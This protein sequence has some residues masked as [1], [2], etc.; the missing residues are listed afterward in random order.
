MCEALLSSISPTSSNDEVK[1]T[2]PSSE[3]EKISS[4][5]SSPTKKSSFSTKKIVVGAVAGAIGLTLATP[6]VITAL[7]FTATGIVGGSI[8]SG[9]MASYGGAVGVGSACA[10]LQSIGAVGLSTTG[11]VG[12]STTGSILGTAV[13]TFIS[14]KNTK[15]IILLVNEDDK[16]YKDPIGAICVFLELTLRPIP[17]WREAVRAM[18]WSL[19]GVNAILK[20]IDLPELE[21]FPL[22][23]KSSGTAVLQFIAKTARSSQEKWKK[24]IPKSLHWMLDTDID[25][26]TFETMDLSSS[27][28]SSS[29]S[30]FSSSSFSSTSTTST[31]NSSSA[32]P[33]HGLRISSQFCFK[34][35]QRVCNKCKDVERSDNYCDKCGESLK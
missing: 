4:T 6:L 31:S 33:P 11:A 30:S 8:A 5:N 25:V 29:S 7:G 27:S 24:Y 23:A 10:V 16:K 14:R 28:S 13:S 19:E 3:E 1:I 15:E 17:Q 21:N 22:E 9:I 18:N 32:C 20:L 12:L 26:S 34:C 2:S 35:G